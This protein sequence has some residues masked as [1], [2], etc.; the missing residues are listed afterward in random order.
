MF[1]WGP[2]R[3][4]K[5]IE[6]PEENNKNNN[7]LNSC[8]TILYPVKEAQDVYMTE[9]QLPPHTHRPKWEGLSEEVIAVIR[10]KNFQDTAHLYTQ[11]N[12]TLFRF[13]KGFGFMIAL[14]S[15]LL[16]YLL[17]ANSEADDRSAEAIHRIIR[18]KTAWQIKADEGILG[19]R[20]TRFLIK[21]NCE[22]GKA[23]S[24]YQQGLER[25]NAR[26]NLIKASSGIDQI[27]GDELLNTFKELAKFD[28][29]VRDV[30]AKDA[31]DDESWRV[32][33]VK[34][35][36]EMRKSIQDERDKLEQ[37]TKGAFSNIFKTL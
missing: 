5:K 29:S 16:G 26:Y 37:L 19:V 9:K 3:R 24:L 28:E 36:Q 14:T 11:K 4:E 1:I 8:C 15:G 27:F 34:A 18:E 20:K 35:N 30:C 33:L 17:K 7:Q 32:F 21:Y 2:R 13:F 10:N 25:F 31:P 6:L 12:E 23:I 22:N